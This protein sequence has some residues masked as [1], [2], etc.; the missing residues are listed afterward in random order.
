MTVE[1]LSAQYLVF[2]GRRLVV[3]EEDA[4]KNLL[5]K[6]D[7]WEPDLPEPD[8]DGHYPALEA[9]AVIQARDILR[10]RRQLGLTQVRLAQLAGIRPETL[11]RIEQGRNKPSVPTIAKIDRA[12][13]KAAKDDRNVVGLRRAQVRK[14]WPKPG[15]N[16]TKPKSRRRK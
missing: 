9:A 13:K 4:Y 16:L 6:A 8:A 11:N 10:A 3:M 14:L 5:T 1:A 7:L 2:E 12:L 15:Q